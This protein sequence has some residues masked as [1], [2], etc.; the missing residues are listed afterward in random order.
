[1]KQQ[2]TAKYGDIIGLSRPRSGRR[3]AM[4]NYDRAAQFSPFAA[5][6]GFDAAI[7]ETGRLT[8]SRVELDEDSRQLLDE[9]MN[10]VLEMIHTQPRV[11]ML[12]FCRD[13]RKDG[14]SYIKTTGCIKKVDTYNRK[15]LLTDSQLIPMEELLS[16]EIIQ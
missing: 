4:S 13:E 14:G 12:W 9:R 1:M 15:I 2:A 5:L 7:A 10:A 6:T 8:D 3:A 11:T 16:L